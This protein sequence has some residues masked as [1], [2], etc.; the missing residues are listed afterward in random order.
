MSL[1]PKLQYT[2][3]AQTAFVFNNVRV[4]LLAPSRVLKCLQYLE[5][6]AGRVGHRMET[7]QLKQRL[8]EGDVLDTFVTIQSHV[9]EG[10]VV[11]VHICLSVAKTSC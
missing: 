4:L 11:D 9:A 6:R 1:E 7:A 2:Y 3:A 10:E 8:A 5:A